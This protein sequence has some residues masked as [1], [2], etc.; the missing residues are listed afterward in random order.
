MSHA[1]GTMFIDESTLGS[2]CVGVAG[3][4]PVR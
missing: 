3:E 2:V 1:S 4:S